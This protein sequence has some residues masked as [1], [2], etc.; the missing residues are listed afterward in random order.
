MTC[1]PFCGFEMELNADSEL[2]GLEQMNRKYL[3]QTQLMD[4]RRLRRKDLSE[5]VLRII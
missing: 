3:L 2:S 5:A 1:S 4:W